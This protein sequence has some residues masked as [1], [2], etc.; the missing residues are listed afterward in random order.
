MKRLHSCRL[1]LLVPLLALLALEPT[2]GITHSP[3]VA[4][5]VD[6]SG[7]PTA[8]QAFV[9]PKPGDRP[10]RALGGWY[11]GVYG[12]YTP[13]GMVLTQV[14]PRTP[15]A[16][17]G[18]EIGD[19]II[20]V[21]GYQIGMT[22]RALMPLDVA[23]QRFVGRGGQARLLVQDRRTN[24]LIQVEVRLVWGDVHT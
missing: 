6:S 15:A 13:T 22:R 17:A 10:G 18:L 9:E 11:L 19:R 2:L 12:R 8:K 24:R 20:A 3:A 21:N 16:R 1:V 5:F 23:L 7:G 4:K 14:Y